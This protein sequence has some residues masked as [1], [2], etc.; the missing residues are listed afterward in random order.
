M[1]PRSLAVLLILIYLSLGLLYGLH[2]DWR[3]A[4]YWAAAAVICFVITF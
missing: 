4:L 3:R 2:G 1:N